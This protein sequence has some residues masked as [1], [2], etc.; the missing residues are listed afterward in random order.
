MMLLDDVETCASVQEGCC[1]DGR[2]I[3]AGLHCAGARNPIG[4][5]QVTCILYALE[6]RLA[7]ALLMR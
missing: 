7:S 6:E 5:S 4:R 1:D 2:V 3:E